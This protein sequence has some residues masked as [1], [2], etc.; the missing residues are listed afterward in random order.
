[1]L[2]QPLHS[3]GNQFG[4]GCGSWNRMTNGS[5]RP[6]RRTFLAWLDHLGRRANQ[7]RG[8]GLADA[9]LTVFYQGIRRLNRY[10]YKTT[11]EA[12]ELPPFKPGRARS[13]LM[14]LTRDEMDVLYAACE[15]DTLGLRDRAMLALYYGCGLR[16]SEG[17]AL[18]VSDV[19]LGRRL[20]YIRQGKGS[21]ERYVPMAEGVVRDLKTYLS[22]AR[23][24]LA[25]LDESA[26]LV[27]RGGKRLKTLLPRL[28]KLV[29][30]ASE[31]K[32]ALKE[33]AVVL[34]TLRHSIA[35]HLM[36]A[37]MPMESV[38][39]F[40]GHRSLESTQIYTHVTV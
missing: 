18:N 36:Q 2:R 20:L 28:N 16:R 37:E 31:L 38:Q 4:N 8:G 39:Q 30:K 23:P 12:F 24:V 6:R 34:H 3:V 33:K 14:V 13:R 9:T 1:M 5:V 22:H 21:V 35:T 15:R 32:P 40:L 26:L 7:L 11:G 17:I 29:E 27:G 10:L 25:R 19:L